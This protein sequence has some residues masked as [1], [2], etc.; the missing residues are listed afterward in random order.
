SWHEAMWLENM[1]IADKD[2]GGWRMVDE[3]AT[4]LGG[5]LPVDPSGGVLCANPTGAT[6]MIRFA[7]AAMQVRGQAGEHQVDGARIALGHAQGGAAS[8]V[9]AWLVGAE[10]P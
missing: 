5:D 2:G 1:L 6:G 8:Y 7:E 9:A 3:G 4:A 10:K